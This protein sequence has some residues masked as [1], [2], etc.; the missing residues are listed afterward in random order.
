MPKPYRSPA[1]Q[2]AGKMNEDF[3]CFYFFIVIS[4][5]VISYS[6]YINDNIEIMFAMYAYFF[7]LLAY[8]AK[9]FLGLMKI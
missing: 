9:Y 4:V 8:F 5:L 1:S 2:Q 6:T 7:D 3:S